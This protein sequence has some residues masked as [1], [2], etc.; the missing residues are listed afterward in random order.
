[1]NDINRIQWKITMIAK[2]VNDLPF[3]TVKI[4]ETVSVF[5]IYTLPCYY[6]HPTALSQL[7]ICQIPFAEFLCSV[8]HEL[9]IGPE[10]IY[11]NSNFLI[12][13]A[14]SVVP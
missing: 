5:Y 4:P 12:P 13:I 7:N 11:F 2:Y 1:V 8:I 10:L 14:V 9:H 6:R 3:T